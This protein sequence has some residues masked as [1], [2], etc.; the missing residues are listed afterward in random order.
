MTL[1]IY[2]KALGP[3]HP[4]TATSLN[5]LGSLLKAMGDLSGARPY[6][7]RALAIDEKVL[8]KEHPD[9]AID[10]GNLGS[11]VAALGD[12]EEGRALLERAL[13]IFLAKLGPNHPYTQETLRRLS[14]LDGE[15]QRA[16]TL[17]D[18][19]GMVRA[20]R[21]GDRQAG[22]QAW[23]IAGQ[24]VTHPDPTVQAVGQ[25]LRDLL[26]GLP[27]DR[28]LAPLPEALQAAFLAALE[29]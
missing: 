14:A 1:A 28:A 7:E 25:A 6:Y 24:L 13:Q 17:D 22:Q 20:A 5:N 12:V 21:G 16:L 10:Y 2:E 19:A 8:G 27:P 3:E 23:D 18:L 9:T 26:A 29:G 11:L 4:W 15:G